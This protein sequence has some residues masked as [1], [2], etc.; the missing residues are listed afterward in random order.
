MGRLERSCGRS[1]RSASCTL[2]RR[3]R[4]ADRP[5]E[6]ARLLGPFF[7]GSSDSTPRSDPLPGVRWSRRS[8]SCLRAADVVSL[9]CPLTDETRNLVDAGRLALDE[10]GRAAR[11]RLARRRWSTRR[12]LAAA[13]H[14]GRLAARRSTC[15]SSGAARRRRSAALGA[16][17][18]LLTNHSRGT[19]RRRSSIAACAAGHRGSATTSPATERRQIA[20]RPSPNDRE[21]LRE[22][23]A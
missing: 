16:P 8:T 3:R 12:P 14:A 21:R 10:A 23:R 22:P 1:S 4:R 6:V 17:N 20:V 13:L 11:Q 2:G 9:H 5:A 15:S 18:L 7:A 19:P